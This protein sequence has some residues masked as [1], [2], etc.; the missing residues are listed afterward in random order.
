[1]GLVKACLSWRYLLGGSL[2]G[3]VVLVALAQ[4]TNEE[5]LRAEERLKELAS[6]AQTIT[7]ATSIEV[8]DELR[9]DIDKQRTRALKCVADTELAI[10][11]LQKEQEILQPAAPAAPA[12]A[13]DGAADAAATV[14]PPPPETESE[15][16][17]QR[18]QALKAE[19][20]G[21]EERLA[22]CR[23]L[24]LRAEELLQT[25][26][27]VQQ[28]KLAQR[29]LAR[30]PHVLE[31]V[32]ANIYHPD[33]WGS[34][35]AELTRR[36]SA[37]NG[38]ETAELSGVVAV[39]LLG[40]AA[41]VV[42][43][44]RL[45]LGDPGTAAPVT[46]LGRLMLSLKACGARQAPEFLAL[47]PVSVALWLATRGAIDPPFITYLAYGLLALAVAVLLTRTL[48]KP[49]LPAGPVFGL[50]E[51]V[52][53]PLSQRLQV[54]WLVMLVGS[55]LF[56]TPLVEAL[57]EDVY[58]LARDI[59]I[60]FL[61]ANIVWLIWLAG[62]LEYFRTHWL[63][64]GVLVLSFVAILGAELLGYR[65]LAGG[66]VRSALQTLFAM[67]GL[68]VLL[69]LVEEA[70]DSLDEGQGRVAAGIRRTLGIGPGDYVPG[71]GW[72]RLL[73]ILMLWVG[74]LAVLLNIWGLSDDGFR[75]IYRYISEGFDIGNFRLV[76]GELLGAVLVFALM[77]TLIGWFKNQ[78]EQ[79]WLA[80]VRMDRGAKEALVTTSGYVGIAIAVLVALS[81]AGLQ[82][83]NLA[84]IAGALSVG[85]GF[86]LQNVVNNFVSG[87]ILLME[88]PIRTGDWIVVGA[89]QGYVKR[90]SIRSTQIQTF[91]R[92]DV[93][94]P[95]SELI[96][97]QVTNWMLSDPYGRL[98]LPVGVA[99][100]SD[101]DKVQE[102]MQKAAYD[103][104]LVVHGVIGLM[105]PKV[106]FIGFGDNSL[107]FE[108]WCM[109]R[110]VDMLMSTKS[111][112]YF[113]VEKAFREHG[114]EIPFPQRDLHVRTWSPPPEGAAPDS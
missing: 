21:L 113:T 35:I 81:M 12:P 49:C 71:I 19:L 14:P 77:L 53:F 56:Y 92:A 110:E 58:L 105:E 102:I 99:Y 5:V 42:I 55:L 74:L 75:V 95:N 37:L 30:G 89:T 97:N 4:A 79:R 51:D 36:A 87:L 104:P 83:T 27:A 20:A 106:M 109:L 16:L 98:K 73:I 50:A 100:G 107:N 44:R 90:I 65:N 85:I 9:G 66:V 29:L 114:I 67:G 47:A 80:K 46:A 24:T 91:D 34:S 18:R 101:V 108:L 13:A 94:V 2:M 69:Q 88:R 10:A 59:Y 62:Y 33:R 72:L 96:S 22:L 103:H 78:M 26:N 54:L 112:L 28:R 70:F 43:R 64:R 41:G 93:I 15:A 8:F 45:V 68:A 84:L 3:A 82:L 32:S 1:M 76:P 57:H 48:L 111:D 52:A 17:G 86:G 63:L 6:A 39:G 11:R 38:L 61:V 23:L 25:V 31:V 7:V 40:F 60:A